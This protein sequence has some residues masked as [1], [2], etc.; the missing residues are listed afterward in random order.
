MTR[1]GAGVTRP[2]VANG[3][4]YV[5]SADDNFYAFALRS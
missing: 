4:V 3:V 1:L 2:A 5:G